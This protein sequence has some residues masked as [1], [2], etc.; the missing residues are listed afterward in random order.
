[1]TRP[2]FFLCEISEDLGAH[3]KKCSRDCSDSGTLT[4]LI[5]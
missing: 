4:I 5:L 3:F 2:R 1:M